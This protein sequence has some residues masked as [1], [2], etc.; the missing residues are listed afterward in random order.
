MTRMGLQIYHRL[1]A[2]VPI[3]TMCGVS[4][5]GTILRTARAGPPRRTQIQAA[6][7]VGVCV[8]TWQRWEYD[9]SVPKTRN[10]KRIA[11]Y[12]GIPLHELLD[13]IEDDAWDQGVAVA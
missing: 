8:L 2:R 5:L 4:R 12:L 9:E 6:A 13:A 11:K 10:L 1:R 3:G 7:G